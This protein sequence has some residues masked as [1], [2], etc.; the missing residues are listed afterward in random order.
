MKLHKPKPETFPLQSKSLGVNP[1]SGSVSSLGLVFLYS[2]FCFCLVRGL[3]GKLA[4]AMKTKGDRC[5]LL[6]P[7]TQ[8]RKRFYP[9]ATSFTGWLPLTNQWLLTG[10][11]CEHRHHRNPAYLLFKSESSC[12]KG[13]YSEKERSLN[14]FFK[15]VILILNHAKVQQWLGVSKAVQHIK[16]TK[17]FL[18][19]HSMR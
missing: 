7:E 10:A 13:R 12:F 3:W 4:S 14:D 17:Y 18:L 1:A 5:N 19:W 2:Q 9:F 6:A 15:R 11:G 16:Y 8:N